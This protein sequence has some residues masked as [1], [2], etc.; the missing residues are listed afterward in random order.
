MNILSLN[1]NKD[2]DLKISLKKITRAQ[3]KFTV[4]KLTVFKFTQLKKK[5]LFYWLIIYKKLYNR[6]D[7]H[8]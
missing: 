4:F 6:N 7:K 1:Y 8:K 2:Q 5:R 3:I